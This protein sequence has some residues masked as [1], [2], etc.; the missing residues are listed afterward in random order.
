MFCIVKIIKLQRAVRQ[1]VAFVSFCLGLLFPVGCSML[2]IR[3]FGHKYTKSRIG[4][5]SFSA[6]KMAT[7][8][9]DAPSF[10]C[11]SHLCA[12][13]PLPIAAFPLTLQN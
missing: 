6:K 2:R 10:S 7:A 12:H 11:F 8:A 3:L 4:L 5:A 13:F 9:P 1:F